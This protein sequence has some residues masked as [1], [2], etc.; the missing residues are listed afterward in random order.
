MCVCKELILPGHLWLT[1]SQGQSNPC[2]PFFLLFFLPPPCLSHSFSPSSCLSLF[3]PSCLTSLSHT[4][5]PISLSVSPP[6]LSLCLLHPWSLSILQNV[7]VRA[8]WM[9]MCAF[10]SPKYTSCCLLLQTCL[11]GPQVQSLHHSASGILC[12]SILFYSFNYLLLYLKSDSY[13]S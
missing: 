2:L 11:T 6:S 1:H 8:A 5:S 4:S 12:S 9:C 13:L 10:V 3:C 7:C